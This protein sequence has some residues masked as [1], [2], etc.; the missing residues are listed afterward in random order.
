MKRIICGTLCLLFLLSLLGCQNSV[1]EMQDAVVFYYLR[2]EI[3][4][5]SSFG[6]GDSVIVPEIQESLSQNKSLSYLIALYLNGPSDSRLQSPFP[7]ELTLL[8][9][10]REQTEL[11][12][13]LSESL[14]ELSGI[15]LTQACACLALTCFHLS[16]AR[17]VTIQTDI[18]ASENHLSFTIS[19][20]DL[21]LTDL[22]P[23]NSD[24]G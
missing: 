18:Q 5:D 8:S 7:A 20:D 10:H 19:R 24:G 14:A 6:D 13:T 22:T 3:T 11:T 4:A 16:D 9:V 17:T 1:A 23:L 2:S 15:S 21:V 12:I